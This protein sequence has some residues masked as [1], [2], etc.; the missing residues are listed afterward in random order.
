M[1]GRRKQ[2]ENLKVG[3]WLGVDHGRNHRVDCLSKERTDC[4]IT[5]LSPN[6]LTIADRV[7]DAR[8]HVTEPGKSI[9]FALLFLVTSDGSYHSWS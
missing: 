3:G 2:R 4:S 1:R 8:E 9:I 7:N 6:F 5:D